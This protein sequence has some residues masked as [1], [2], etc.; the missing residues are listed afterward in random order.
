MKNR[1]IEIFNQLLIFPIIITLVS[2]IRKMLV[3]STI[4]KRII[5]IS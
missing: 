2:P 5:L 1:L 3:L 4:R